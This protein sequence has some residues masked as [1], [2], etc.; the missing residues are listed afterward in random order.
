MARKPP[1]ESSGNGAGGIT[2]ASAVY[3]QL[4]WDIT[5]GILEPGSKLRVE[6]ISQRYKVG[7]SPLR[8]ALSRMS[9]EG[10]VDRAVGRNFIGHCA[11]GRNFES[12]FSRHLELAAQVVGGLAG[13]DLPIKAIGGVLPEVDGGSGQGLP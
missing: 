10:L 5:H 7:A 6:A 12:A 4:R 9:A 1:L 11:N 8:E 13:V 2:R 3:E